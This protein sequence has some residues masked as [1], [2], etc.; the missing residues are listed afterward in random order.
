MQPRSEEAL[1]LAAAARALEAGTDGLPLHDD[2]R[3]QRVDAEA[4]D[5]VG[6]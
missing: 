3:R 1:D 6:P 2:E 4:L 5:E